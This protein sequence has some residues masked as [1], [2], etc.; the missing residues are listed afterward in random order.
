VRRHNGTS[1]GQPG[2]DV[3]A[4]RVADVVAARLER[5]AERRHPDVPQGAAG[6]HG[7]SQRHDPLAAAEVRL[8]HRAEQR[9]QGFRAQPRGDRLE[10]PDVLGQAAAAE[11]QPRGQEVPADPR[12]Q[13][14]RVGQFQHV[15][16]RLLAHLGHHV[17]ERDLGGQERVGGHL[18]ELRGF[19]PGD[20]QRDAGR[21][22]G[23]VHLTDECLRPRSQDAEHD[24]VRGEAVGYRVPLAQELGVPRQVHRFPGRGEGLDAGEQP[25]RRADRHGGLADHQ[26]LP[27]QVRG[28]R[29]GGSVQLRQVRLPALALRRAHTQEVHVSEG[30]D[31]GEGV[32]EP[33]P[34][35]VEVLAQQGLQAGL[36]ERRSPGRGQFQLAEVGVDGQ[37]VVTEVRHADRVGQAQVTSADHGDP[38][39]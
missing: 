26:A 15:G 27:E 33:Q 10:R 20:H 25:A 37:H 12:V 4:G 14:D 36:E 24:P 6:R 2:A 22:L 17:D 16:A 18:H 19:Q 1:I 9:G 3:E 21:Q 23:G 38:E 28:Q 29:V 7:T 31:L 5:Q 13:P 8:V 11:A 32:G 35:G 34:A 39:R 30:A